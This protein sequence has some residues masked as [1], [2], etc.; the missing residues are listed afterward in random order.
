MNYN[1]DNKNKLED[2]IEFLPEITEPNTHIIKHIV[3]SGGGT[4]GLSYYGILRESQKKNIWNI[5]DIQ[6]IYGTSIGSILAVML[7]LKYDWDTLDDYLIKRPW[8]NVFHYD[9][10]TLL[11]CVQNNGTIHTCVYLFHTKSGDGNVIHVI[12]QRISVLYFHII[13]L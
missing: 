10:N 2:D 1:A 4:T 9:I 11:S 5:E 12:F 3:I 6:T 8:Q 7:C 13:V